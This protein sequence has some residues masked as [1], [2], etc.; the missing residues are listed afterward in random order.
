M[1]LGLSYRGSVA[2]DGTVEYV[3]DVSARDGSARRSP[4][5]RSSIDNIISSRLW[6]SRRGMG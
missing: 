2:Y 3:D 5:T 1:T 6:I 4:T